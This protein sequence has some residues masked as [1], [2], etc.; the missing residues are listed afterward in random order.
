MTIQPSVE[1]I[2]RISPDEQVGAE[3][4]NHLAQQLNAEILQLDVDAV[5]PVISGAS[6]T[7]TKSGEMIQVGQLMVTLA[8]TLVGPLFEL[9]KSWTAR[10]KAVPVK[11]K[12]KVGRKTADLEYDPTTTSAAQLNALIRGLEKTLRDPKTE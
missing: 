2:V 10:R 9:L 3:E 4:L 11:L 7:G 8:P 6:P 12:L 1:V 5:E